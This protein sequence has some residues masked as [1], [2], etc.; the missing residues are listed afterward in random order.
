[1]WRAGADS[2]STWQGNRKIAAHFRCGVQELTAF[3]ADVG[4]RMDNR[5]VLQRLDILQSSFESAV[6]RV[7]SGPGS[8]RSGSSSAPDPKL[9]ATVQTLE[10]SL[11]SLLDQVRLHG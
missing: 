8:S 9:L 4:G 1:M 5:A 11:T 7:A 10:Q 2:V 6:K 3:Q